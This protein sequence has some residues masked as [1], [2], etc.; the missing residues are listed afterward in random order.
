M[1]VI[2]MM[3]MMVVVVVMVAVVSRGLVLASLIDGR[4]LRNAI[5][6]ALPYNIG[7][8]REAQQTLDRFPARH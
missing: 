7:V 6:V 3:M 2:V 1:L 4:A 5:V 8:H